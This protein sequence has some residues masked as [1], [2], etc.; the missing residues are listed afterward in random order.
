[1]ERKLVAMLMA[2]TLSACAEMPVRDNPQEM[3][4]AFDVVDGAT[5]P[6][7]LKLNTIELTRKQLIAAGVTPKFVVAFRGEASYYTQTDLAKVKEN[8][9]ADALK[10]RALIKDLS[11]AKGIE[12]LEQCTVPLEMRK[13]KPADVMPEVKV[14]Q[15]GWI[16][17]GAYQAKGYG[18]IS[19]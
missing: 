10:I 12:S 17:L 8:D 2:A 4:L 3:K 16:A 7:M 9:R 6:L 15:N 19:P 18:Y 1:M 14:V 13:I 5:A 11:K